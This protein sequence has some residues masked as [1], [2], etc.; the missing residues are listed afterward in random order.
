MDAATASIIA[1]FL[2]PLTA[3][4]TAVIVFLI[5]RMNKQERHIARLTRHLLTTC[6]DK[7]ESV[8][9][10]ADLIVQNASEDGA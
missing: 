9:Q 4:V 7:A 1:T 2:T 8:E 3:I 5:R 6:S 10:L